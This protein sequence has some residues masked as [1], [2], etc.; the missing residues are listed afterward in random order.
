MTII[1][2]EIM[3]LRELRSVTKTPKLA[4][5]SV[6]EWSSSE[7]VVKNN[8]VEEEEQ[9]FH[10]PILGMWAAVKKDALK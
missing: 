2:L 8:L 6:M 1:P 10:C 4:M 7:D 9:L 5:K 3:I